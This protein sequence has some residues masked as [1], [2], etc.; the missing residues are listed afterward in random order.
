MALEAFFDSLQGINGALDIIMDSGC[1]YIATGF[2]NDFKKGTLQLLKETIEL[3]GIGSR[4]KATHQGQV[5]YEYL[6]D[7]GNLQILE[8]T[9][10]YI[11]DLKY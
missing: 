2:E 1:S 7:K 8:G 11:P 6:D 5:E 9:G 4:L 3:D 10:L